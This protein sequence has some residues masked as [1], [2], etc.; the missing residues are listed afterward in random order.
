MESKLPDIHFTL[1]S[2]GNNLREECTV[3]RKARTVPSPT[4]R[5]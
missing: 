4:A 3:C 1:T 5:R 2:D